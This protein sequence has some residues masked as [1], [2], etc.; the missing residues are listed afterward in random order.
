MAKNAFTQS[1]NIKE[2]YCASIIRVGEVTPVENSDFLVKTIIGGFPIVCNKA[3]IKSGD[4]VIYCKNETELDK[5]FLSVNNMFEMG[6]RELN[7]NYEE[8][9][10]LLDEG[11]DDEAKKH[12]G[13]FN[14]HGR[15]KMIRL[16]GCPSMGIIIGLKPLL[17]WKSELS[18]NEDLESYLTKDENGNEIPFNFDTVCGEK[19]IKAY[20]PKVNVRRSG[21][22]NKKSKHVK[23]L[24]RFNRLIEGTF[25]FHYDT[26]QLNDN[27]WRIT[28]DSNV[29]ISI[30]LH[31]T[32]AIF[33]NI[34]T[35]IPLKLNWWDRLV[36]KCVKFASKFVSDKL[37]YIKKHS[38]QDYITVY[39]DVYSSRKVIKNEFINPNATAGNGYYSVDVWSWMNEKLSKYLWKGMTVYGE[40][41][42][43][44]PG[45]SKYIQNTPGNYDYGCE[46]GTCKFMPYRITILNPDGTKYEMNVADVK[47]WTEMMML[48]P[49][50]KDIMLPIPIL[51]EGTLKDLYPDIN[52]ENHWHENVL[53]RMKEYD[54][55]KNDKIFGMEED[56]PLC[57]N[58]VPRE[59]IVIRIND[60]PVAEA[61]KLKSLVFLAKEAKNIDKGI[62]DAEMAEEYSDGDSTEEGS[63]ENV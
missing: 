37:E 30:K 45:T 17:N 46:T 35:K 9:Q 61:F 58:K 20:V 12:V 28:P 25:A 34:L 19:F 1:E 4:V 6:S 60:D 24:E 57:K 26:K 32:S 22:G 48:M 51:Y 7:T 8:V 3:D 50:L 13:F 16:R 29:V 31:G 18:A 10:K 40:I 15:V 54:I 2:E 53:E 21:G 43:F 36:N 11:K 41:V 39:D 55:P 33:S 47:A 49:D 63:E 62:V 44:E 59:G 56:E 27:M 38:V 23:K 5:K 52:T 42:G 14:K